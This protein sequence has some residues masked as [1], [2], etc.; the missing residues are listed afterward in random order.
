MIACK[1][2]NLILIVT[3]TLLVFGNVAAQESDPV[4][5]IEL[6]EC[7]NGEVSGIVVGVDEL[8]SGIAIVTI[9]YSDDEG[10]N[11]LCTLTVEDVTSG[12][13]IM[14]LL[15]RFYGDVSAEQLADALDV[16]QVCLAEVDGDLTLVECEV[17]HDFKASVIYYD[18]G[19]LTVLIDGE[20]VEIEVDEDLEFGQ[21]VDA[22]ETLTVD[23]ELLDGVLVQTKD[24]IAAYHEDGLGFGVLVKLYSM[25]EEN[26][27]VTID[28]LVEM[29][30]G[31]YG[32]GELFAIYGKP[33][34]LGVGHV[35]QALKGDNENGDFPGL[36]VGLQINQKEKWA[37]VEKP[38]N[39]LGLVEDKS[40][41]TSENKPPNISSKEDKLELKSDNKNKSNQGICIARASG[42][43]ANANGK[44]VICP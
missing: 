39:S 37:E 3:L 27:D 20:P 25:A 10:D 14:V 28:D 31:G 29:S 32:M 8:E 24:E 15:G 34:F 44:S 9:Y 1:K 19:F 7:Q 18:D 30:A 5:P 35:R 26:E 22:L 38:G 33:S 4:E 12:H 43:V 2:I 17:E 36:G 40:D 41:N 16:S 23:W 42:G 21:I 6:G 13:P 11:G